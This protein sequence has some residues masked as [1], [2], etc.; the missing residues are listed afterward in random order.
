MTSV[1]RAELTKLTRRRVLVAAPVVAA[2]FATVAAVTVFLAAQP[3][4]A[5]APGRGVTLNELA[6]PGGGTRAFAVG[7]SFAGLLVLV[8]FVANVT[9]EF[10]QGTFRTL[11]MRQP[12]RIRLLVGKMAALV[13]VAA[14]VL[15][16]AEALTLVAS[17]VVA[18][19]RGVSTSDWF[20][21][22]SLGEAAQHYATAFFAVGSWALLGMGLAVVVR[23]TPVALAIA[24]AWAGPFEHLL[25]DAW[26]AASRWFPGLLIEALAAGGTQDVSF[27]RASVLVV[28]Y[29]VVTAGAALTLF[30]RRDVTS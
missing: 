30:A 18:R 25:Q 9:V 13:L 22:S 6:G 24:I 3:A 2:V 28:G 29:V 7:A 19:T 17:M 26:T 8:T 5:G 15:L 20:S 4:G 11:L 12:G 10:S 27:P 1:I 23:S 14:A 21:L 16:L